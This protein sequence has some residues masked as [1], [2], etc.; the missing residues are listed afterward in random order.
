MDKF[1][2]LILSGGAHGP[3]R[4][5]LLGRIPQLFPLANTPLL[6][7]ALETIR[8]ASIDEVIIAA[9]TSEIDQLRD[10]VGDPSDWDLSIAYLGAEEALG[11]AH[12]VSLTEQLVGESPLLVFCGPTLITQPIQPFLDRF[13]EGELDALALVGTGAGA[14]ARRPEIAEIGSC[15]LGP[16][17]YDAAAA[18]GGRQPG[19][20]D[21]EAAISWLVA[22]GGRVETRQVDGWWQNTGRPEDLLAANRILLDR[23]VDS[24]SAVNGRDAQV[25]GRVLIDDS[26]T[27]ESSRVR[28][29][30]VIGAGAR[31]VD[32]YVGPYTSVGEQATIESSEVENA[33]I[34]P[35]ATIE[36][37]G[38][39]VEESV[40]GEGAE[41][42]RTFR[43]PR[44]VSLSIGTE[45][46]IALS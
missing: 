39:R 40:I 22:A 10:A 25:E 45:A 44:G 15:I 34:L 13:A 11:S 5:E 16:R 27:I 32:S 36:H 14:E 19:K 30:S 9:G 38:L 33:I 18:V 21:L 24:V 7:Y 43:V 31:I 17:I 3:V 12:A 28:G 1:M 20:D 37:F 23:L 2:G 26:A 46:E 8:S 41:L 6:F 42:H 4:R 29:P 35:R